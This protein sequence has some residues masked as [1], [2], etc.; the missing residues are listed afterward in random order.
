[1]YIVCSYMQTLKDWFTVIM[2]P[3]LPNDY[4]VW[5]SFS[6]PSVLN[7]FREDDAIARATGDF[8]PGQYIFELQVWD[9]ESLTSKKTLTVDVQDKPSGN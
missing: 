5:Y 8:I 4:F 7:I 3:F 9:A 2:W 6:G 1:M